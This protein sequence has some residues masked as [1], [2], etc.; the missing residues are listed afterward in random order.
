[1]KTLDRQIRTI[2]NL[3]YVDPSYE[4]RSYKVDRVGS[5]DTLSVE[6]TYSQP[7]LRVEYHECL[8]V[9]PRGGVKKVYKSF[10]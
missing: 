1:M 8:F 2:L 5:T 7:G 9:G 3:T 6:R 4:L 10:Y